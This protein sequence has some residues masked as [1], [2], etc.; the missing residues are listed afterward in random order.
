MPT[1]AAITLPSTF[2]PS[3]DYWPWPLSADD[4]AAL[5]VA[6][7]GHELRVLG[8]LN[9]VRP[10]VYVL[11]DGSGSQGS[12]RLDYTCDLLAQSGATQGS[13]FG[14][15]TDRQLYQHAFNGNWDWFTRI[16]DQLAESWTALCVKYVVCDA[17][18]GYSSSHD[19]CR[20]L[21]TR[22]AQASGVRLFDVSLTDRPDAC[23]RKLCLDSI[24]LKLQPHELAEKIRT[25][26]AYTPLASDVSSNLQTYGPHSFATECLRAT[27]SVS[28]LEFLLPTNP[29]YEA[30]GRQQFE[31][32]V[33][34]HVLTRD[35]H[36]VPLARSLQTTRRK[37][38]A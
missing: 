12:G 6:H 25:A 7:P 36:L 38:A 33:Y 21:A 5:V 22:A 26:R 27:E 35:E 8:W 10:H 13:L 17:P 23:P 14:L 9:R 31:R 11:T 20:L 34:G 4:R 37:M 18:E 3:A 16:V 29:F 1:S 30:Y 19:I 15:A 24:W 28:Q 32:G 2:P